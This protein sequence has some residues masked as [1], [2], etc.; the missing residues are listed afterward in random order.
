MLVANATCP[1]CSA[2]YLA[3]MYDIPGRRHRKEG[4]I[5]DLS[6]RSTFDDEPGIPDLPIGLHWDSDGWV[7]YYKTHQFDA[8]AKAT[9]TRSEEARLHV[10]AARV[11]E[12]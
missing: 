2:E 1:G 11:L 10:E 12:T 6:F 5:Q 9:E 8:W 4:G 7:T 3:W